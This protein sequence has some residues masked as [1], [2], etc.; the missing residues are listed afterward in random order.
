MLTWV[1][2]V[3][4]GGCAA[5]S[6]PEET[7][8]PCELALEPTWPPG[9][10]PFEAGKEGVGTSQPAWLGRSQVRSPPHNLILQTE[11]L[12]LQ[13]IQ[14]IFPVHSQEGQASNAHG[15]LLGSRR[16]L[17][18]GVSGQPISSGHFCHR[19]PGRKPSFHLSV[20]MDISTRSR[21]DT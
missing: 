15:N 4:G 18:T 5:P 2:A 11:G 1:G 13:K 16:L 21:Q 7:W 14:R 8:P 9:N 12:R 20:V 19:R 10:R 6:Q 3:Q 17:G